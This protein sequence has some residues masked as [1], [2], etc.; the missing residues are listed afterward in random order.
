MNRLRNITNVENDNSQEVL[1][2][3]LRS[4]R[5]E[6]L[7]ELDRLRNIMR[8]TDIEEDEKYKNLSEEEKSVF[9]Q[10]LAYFSECPIC[11]SENHKRYLLKFYFD[12]DPNKERLKDSLLYLMY[13]VDDL[14]EFFYN[15]ITL[16]IP[17]CDCFKKFFKN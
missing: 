9:E 6:M 3:G 5:D 10:F 1:Y 2:G 8:G 4:L 17:C 12:T 11:K 15:K 14:E 7:E 13:E 16:G